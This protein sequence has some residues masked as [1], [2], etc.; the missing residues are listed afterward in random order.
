[1]SFSRL[2]SRYNGAIL[3]RYNR[4]IL[5]L[6]G[7]ELS[8]GLSGAVVST[9]STFLTVDSLGASPVA[10]GSESRTGVLGGVR[11]VACTYG[12]NHIIEKNIQHVSNYFINLC[13][14]P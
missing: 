14:I 10:C 8:G 1:M 5:P 7:V 9:S 12:E 6:I 13:D 2:T 11:S 3:L 4:F